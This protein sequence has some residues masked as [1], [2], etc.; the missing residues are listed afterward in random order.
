MPIIITLSAVAFL[1]IYVLKSGLRFDGSQLSEP[2]TAPLTIGVQIICGD[3]SG[4]GESPVKTYLDRHGNCLQ[5]GGHSYMLAS[6]RLLY[7]RQ[8]IMTRISRP[9]VQG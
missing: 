9:E 3:C 2:R 6:C 4:E 1:V 8:I 5:C 7:A